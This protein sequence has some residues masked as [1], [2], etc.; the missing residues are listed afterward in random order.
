MQFIGHLNVKG[1]LIKVLVRPHPY[2]FTFKIRKSGKLG[3]PMPDDAIHF[4][5]NPNLL[6]DLKAGKVVKT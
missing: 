5:Q 6:T 1:E 2:G 4:E 3:Q